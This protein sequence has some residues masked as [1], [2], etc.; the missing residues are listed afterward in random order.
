M[1]RH[2][3]NNF[4]DIA[5]VVHHAAP[6]LAGLQ[7]EQVIGVHRGSHPGADFHFFYQ[8][9]GRPAGIA[10]KKPDIF[11]FYEFGCDQK[12]QLATCTLSSNK[13]PTL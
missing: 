10:N 3:R 1:L 9:A 12:F 8:L 11:R 2:I 4:V 5:F 13:S 7:F 6:E